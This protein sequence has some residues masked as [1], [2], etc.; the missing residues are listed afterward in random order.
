MP[1]RNGKVV[2]RSPIQANRTFAQHGIH[3]RQ[4]GVFLLRF[5]APEA[6]A[7][8]AL[9]HLTFAV[10]SIDRPKMQMKTE[11]LNQYNKKR[12]VYTGF[13]YEPI[14]VQFYDSFDGAAQNLWTRY[15]RYYFGDFTE[16]V[17]YGYD[18]TTPSF[19]AGPFGFTAANGGAEEANNNAQY[20]FSKISIYH[21][22]DGLCDQYDLINPRIKSY[23]PDELD[24]ESSAVS[25]IA[26]TLVFEN[27]QYFQQFAVASQQFEEFKS[28]H[29]YGNPLPVVDQ[30]FQI[31]AA[32]PLATTS[33]VDSGSWDNLFTGD[34]SSV[35]GGTWD[36]GVGT[37]ATQSFRL[38]GGS[39]SGGSLGI[40][41]NFA[42]GPSGISASLTSNLGSLI[43]GGI[44]RLSGQAFAAA[45]GQVAAFTNG[46][47]TAPTTLTSAV[48]QANAVDDGSWDTGNGLSNA[49]QGAVLSPAAYG[50]VNA[51]QTGTAQYGYNTVST[52]G[53]GNPGDPPLTVGQLAALNA[54]DAATPAAATT[55][56]QQL[57]AKVAANDAALAASNA[58]TPYAAGNVSYT[59][60][61]TQA[62]STAYA[63]GT[64]PAGDPYASSI[65]AYVAAN[66]AEFA[67]PTVA[68]ARRLY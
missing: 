66:K 25:M 3:P 57:N 44:R 9:T 54:Q 48:A 12:Q 36:T 60:P 24:Y 52:P 38:N 63:P 39:T 64:G 32:N 30:S 68:N 51:Q 53:L 4:H 27:I 31:S 42:F 61:P 59:T 20:F 62:T 10:K 41:G 22:Y 45:A 50:A 56:Q 40:F 11:E 37:A 65:N 58:S 5:Q 17:N 1:I 46:Y 8:L 13:N 21:F 2:L 43:S 35:D 26:M 23:D 18:A 47:G 55:Y 67:S 15:A 28:G 16:N 14:R 34:G 29:F 33:I 19:N 49:G 7:P 6:K